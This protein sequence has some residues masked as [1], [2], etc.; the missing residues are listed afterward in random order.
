MEPGDVVLIADADAV[1]RDAAAQCLRAAGF[2]VLL[3]ETGDEAL[4]LAR[5]A[6]PA[7]AVVEIPLE[8]LSGYEVCRA[9]KAELGRDLPV[10][11]ASGTRRESYDRVAGLLIGA[12]DYLVKPVAPDEL[13]A[14]VR[15]L[16]DRTRAP[17]RPA[18][19]LTPREHEV[20]RLLG[21]GLRQRDIAERLVISPKTV[22]THIENILRKLAVR[23][24]AQAVAAAYRQGL[25][26]VPLR[27]H[28]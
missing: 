7:A 22:A 17:E 18:V 1:S 14:R 6:P 27:D 10:V 3:A 9:L 11:F 13:L 8:G 5:R 12:D 24:R 2:G 25:L 21:G 15:R 19:R 28:R 23:S 20:L 4:E 26:D 16:I